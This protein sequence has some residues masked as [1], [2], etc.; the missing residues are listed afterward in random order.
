MSIS[1]LVSEREKELITNTLL[2]SSSK[3]GGKDRV[4]VKRGR[5]SPGACFSVRRADTIN[6]VSANDTDDMTDNEA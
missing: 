2:Q 5:Q 3:L 1:L 6:R 4:R